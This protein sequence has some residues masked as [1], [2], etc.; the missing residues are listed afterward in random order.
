V[1]INVFLESQIV[2]RQIYACTLELFCES[3]MDRRQFSM[4]SFKRIQ[5]I[6]TDSIGECMKLCSKATVNFF[7]YSD[8]VLI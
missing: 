4:E 6:P 7:R 3:L 1:L 2:I 8:R 5:T